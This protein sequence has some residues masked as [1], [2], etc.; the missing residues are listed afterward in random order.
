MTKI[1]LNSISQDIF[2]VNNA[3]SERENIVGM[4]RAIAYDY[5]VRAT[6]GLHS[7]LKIAEKTD[8]L[9]TSAEYSALNK[10]FQQE[11]FLFAAKVAC[12]NNG[13]K[14]PET[15]E[16]FKKN[17]MLYKNN[18]SFLATLMGIYSEILTPIIPA[19]YSE[20]VGMFAEMVTVGIGESYQVTVGSGDIPIFQDSAWG[21]SRSVPRNRFYEKDYTL[22]PQPRTAQCNWKWSQ[23]IGNNV[24]FGKYFA[25]ITAGIYSKTLVL[26][27]AA[28][29][30]AATNPALVPS[31]LQY[32][33]SSTNWVTAANKVAAL[34]GTKISNVMGIGGAVALS[35]V[36]PTD[37]TGSTNVNMDAAIAT[38]LGADYTHTG[39]L[40]EYMAVRLMPI[41]DAIIPNTQ[42]ST[43]QTVLDQTKIWM[44]AGNG[45]KPLTIAYNED[46]PIQLEVDPSKAGDMELA[47]NITISLDAIA[48]FQSKMALI[49]V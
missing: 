29:A 36:L 40:G 10:K 39:Y 6:N 5:A 24:D 22:V 47:V 9:I 4:G 31:G 35:K 7:A 44:M 42:F 38:M 2:A 45:Y 43:V 17:L 27:N 28:M 12:A 37:V 46:T 1:T 21:A 26:W 20:A 48:L 33:F 41:D 13:M 11:H 49:T 18:Q 30:Q 32:T 23:L 16:D 3:A 34:N 8:R 19:V 25:N 15:F 14:A